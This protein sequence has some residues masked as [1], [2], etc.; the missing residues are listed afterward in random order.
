MHNDSL[1]LAEFWTI[2][3]SETGFSLQSLLLITVLS[4]LNWFFEILKWKYLV[5][6]FKPISL[7]RATE[8]T[9]GAHTASLFTPNRIGDY[10][11]K[12]LYFPSNLRAKIMGLNGLGNFAQMY[13]TTFFGSLGLL[14]FSST[15]PIHF[16]YKTLHWS[17]YLIFG[18]LVTA[19]IILAKTYLKPE[20]WFLKIKRFLSAISLSLLMK[21]LLFSTLRYFI[22]SFQFY[23]LLQLFQVDLSYLNTM[24]ALS[25]M[26]LL[27]SI[28]PSVFI[29]DVVLKGSIAVYLFSFFDINGTIIL[30]CITLMWIL[31]V[32]LPSLFGSYFVMRFKLPKS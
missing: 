16:D 8:Q 32:V 10:G 6:T 21:T 14:F 17:Q 18:L 11:A 15:F 31:N 25:S 3:N 7:K 9:L 30:S 28:L 12:A 19:L 29:F 24:M 1:S 5:S 20:T 4:C 23:L 26:Y 22:F 13:V 27:A 2:L